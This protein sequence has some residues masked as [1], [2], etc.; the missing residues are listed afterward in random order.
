MEQVV[1]EGK[2][3]SSRIMV[4]ETIRNVEKYLPGSSVFIIS[5][6]NVTGFHNDKFPDFPLF[7]VEPGEQSKEFPVMATIWQWLLEQGADRSSFIL[8]VGGGVVCDIAGFVAATYMR[9]VPFG[10]VATTL[11]A[12]VDASV[13]GKNGINLYGYKNIIGTFTQPQFVIC[14]TS[15]LSTLPED[16]FISG[17]AEVIK[18]AAIRDRE[19]FDYLL[20]NQTALKR[21]DE[22]AVNHI[23]ARS[24]QIKAAVVQADELEKGERRLLNFGHTWGHA[25]EKVSKVAHGQAVAVGMVFAANLSVVQGFLDP[26]ERDKIMDLLQSY[27]LAVFAEIDNQLVF[28]AMLKDKKRDNQNIHF[29]LLGKNWP[30]LR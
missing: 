20:V 3:G 8:A 26:E 28:D 6:K 12:Q 22:D 4:G 9:G 30:C 11:L 10:F 25:I 13:G 21:R 23:V 27:G 7:V 16:E 17:M 18:H 19:K 2:S 1:I 15:L 14:D 24:V 5:D 29:V